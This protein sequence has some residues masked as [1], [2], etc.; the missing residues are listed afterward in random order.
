MLAAS[1]TRALNEYLDR[2][3]SAHL[4]CDP[5]D[6]G[7]AEEGICLAYAA[8]GLRAPQRVVWFKSPLELA[9]R[10][11]K[12]S[13]HM[14]I[15][16]NVKTEVFDQVSRTIGM[17]AE[18]FWK[19]VVAAAGEVHRPVGAALDGYHKSMLVS[20]ELDRVV[21]RAVDPRLRRLGVRARHA[22]R[23]MHGMPR[24][25]PTAGFDQV[26]IGPCDLRS[27]GVYE[28]LHDVLAWQEPTK[29]LRGLWTIA[30]SAGWLVPHEHVSWICERPICLRTDAR[31]R[32]HCSDGPALRYPDGWSVY[33]WK[34]V[35][36]PA[37]TIEH[38]E[39]ITLTAIADTF[40]PVLRNC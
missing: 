28:Y 11:A 22:L 40:D 1:P 31:G 23:Q 25:L 19:E 14:P 32:L 4:S 10:L 17:F 27:L 21:V 6:R 36:V 34:G 20:A 38:R 33:A 37:W 12:P 24:L 16:P 9:D 26:A 29:P 5:A 3:S 8:V 30:K 2:W 13:P 39:L 15:G 35:E 18:I 7:T